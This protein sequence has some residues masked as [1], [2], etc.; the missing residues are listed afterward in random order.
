MKREL[1]VLRRVGRESIEDRGRVTVLFRTVISV[2]T[3]KLDQGAIR[4]HNVHHISS[5]ESTKFVEQPIM[6]RSV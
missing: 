3:I 1:Y 2:P 6:W 5:N 4:L